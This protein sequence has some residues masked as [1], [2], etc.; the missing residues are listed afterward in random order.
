MEQ[1]KFVLSFKFRT[2]ENQNATTYFAF[3]YP[4]SYTEIQNYLKQIDTKCRS[5]KEQY[6]ES[7][8]LNAIYYHR[9]C[10]TRS[11]EHRRVD[12]VT[13]SSHHGISEE[14]EPRLRY[15]FMELDTQTF[16]NLA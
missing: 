11:M 15:F 13:V 7:K 12:L 5:F 4:F 14:L 8:D 2:L 6:E 9:E 3:T 16:I 10:V 1:K